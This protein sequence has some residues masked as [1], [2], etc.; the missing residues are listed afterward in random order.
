MV[1]S[2]KI[3]SLCLTMLYKFRNGGHLLMEPY[4]LPTTVAFMYMYIVLTSLS[5]PPH[6]T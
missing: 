6:L 2:S 3:F 4:V 5:L 1:I